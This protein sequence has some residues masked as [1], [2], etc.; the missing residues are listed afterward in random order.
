[1]V[2][3]RVTVMSNNGLLDTTPS[4]RV[5]SHKMQETCDAEKQDP[6]KIAKPYTTLWSQW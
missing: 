5:L 4:V 3:V 1:M 6:A 2:S